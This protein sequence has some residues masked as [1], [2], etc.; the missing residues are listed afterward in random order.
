MHTMRGTWDY[1][2]EKTSE[3]HF[4]GSQLFEHDD[5][6]NEIMR[7]S[8]EHADTMSRNNKVFQRTGMM[9]NEVFQFAHRFGI[10]T[11]VGTEVP[12]TVPKLLA[13]RLRE[14][15]QDPSKPEVV[16]QLYQGTFRRIA[17]TYPLDY[18]W[19]WTPEHWMW[20]DP[21]VADEEVE[22]VE[23][24]LLTAISAWEKSE[25]SFK[26][27]TCGWVLGPPKDRARFD[28][29]LPKDVALS[30]ILEN[31][32]KI[33]LEPAMADI[34]GREK[35]AIP[36]PEDDGCLTTPQLWV[37]RMRRDAADALRYGCTGLL[38]Y[39][40]RTRIVGPNL[41][42]LA[43]AAWDQS[44][45][46]DPGSDNDSVEGDVEIMGGRWSLFGDNS[47][48]V[49]E[50]PALY[51]SMEWDIDGYRISVPDGEYK[52]VLKFVEPSYDAPGK[53]L[54][55]VK[56]QGSVVIERL[57]I[58]ARVGMNT[59]LDLAFEAQ[60]TE[61][62]LDIDFE[63]LVGLP[64]IS[65]IVLEGEKATKKI[66]CGGY[67]YKDYCEDAMPY[68]DTWH[69]PAGDF[70][71]DWASHEF[72]PEVADQVARI[73]DRIDGRLPEPSAWQECPGGISLN[74]FPWSHV[75]ELYEF[76][77]EL[78]ELASQVRGSGNRERF[79]YWLDSFRAMREMARVGCTLSELKQVMQQIEAETNPAMKTKLARARALPLRRKLVSQW[80][81]MVTLI[82][83]T[84]TNTSEMGML[85]NIEQ[86]SLRHLQRLE[87]YDE[88]LEAALGQALPAD[89]A[90]WRDY[91]G[92]ARLVVPTAR[93]FLESGEDLKLR[94]IVLTRD[95]PDGVSL[96]W[97]PLGDDE[98]QQCSLGHVARGVY[99]VVLPVAA[100][101]GA[102]FEYYLEANVDG[103]KLRYPAGAPE[104]N[105][106]VVVV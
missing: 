80:G 44:E 33:P 74:P 56:L 22:I 76:V 37:G 17:Q 64:V 1:A 46:T 66:N 30:Y 91:R 41:L 27:A 3:Y 98:Y 43:W 35:W 18:Y 104:L 8:S 48:K 51:Q 85:A 106:T 32:G 83:G 73:F 9:L 40:W 87:R 16:E 15:G 103:K 42:A 58:A 89:T 61:G 11:C 92:P 50:D 77:D 29:T 82:L 65:A 57:D 105:Q 95:E 86:H 62:H 6:G 96:F 19:L 79:A 26:L 93:T 69:V 97:R 20:P 10:K 7:G 75:A 72:G 53:R 28:K 90:P 5:Y 102:D 24:D 25:A 13:D 101:K 36:W 100:I 68:D 81:E 34:E 84:A 71:A 67:A 99:S 55:T 60:V 94:A 45:W 54:F 47:V 70:Y 39:L 38:G 2:P 78:A 52:V 21:S 14:R 63:P 49:T 31:T 59:A 12:L 4:G 88:A 23:G